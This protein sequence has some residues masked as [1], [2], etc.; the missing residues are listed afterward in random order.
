MLENKIDEETRQTIVE[1][2][3][4]VEVFFKIMEKKSKKIINGD[5]NERKNKAITFI[6]QLTVIYCSVTSLFL[7]PFL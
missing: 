5:E 2:S 3:I 7:K 1:K 4:S 6:V